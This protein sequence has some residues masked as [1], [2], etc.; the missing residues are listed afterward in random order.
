MSSKSMIRVIVQY[1]DATLAAHVGGPV[2]TSYLTFD[3]PAPELVNH[4]RQPV[5]LGHR[6]IVGVE[7]LP[8][9]DARP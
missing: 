4:M 7:V 8:T 2:E 9:E 1:V 3:I 6:T 5:S